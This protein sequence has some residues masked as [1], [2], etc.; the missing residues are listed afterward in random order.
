MK[1]EPVSYNK[2]IGAFFFGL[3]QDLSNPDVNI[4]EYINCILSILP[5]IHR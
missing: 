4:K 2:T 1:R 5:E 3:R